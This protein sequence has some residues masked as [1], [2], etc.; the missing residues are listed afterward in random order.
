MASETADSVDG[1]A[2]RLRYWMSRATGKPFF[3]VGLVLAS[4]S[5]LSGLA[6]YLILTGL[7]PIIPTHQVVVTVLLFNGVLAFGMIVLIAWQVAGLWIAR[8]RQAPGAR[9]HA[10]IVGM[11]SIIAVLP[12]ILL[13]VFASVSLDRGLDHWF[14]TR[15]QSIV[16]NS[17]NVARAY[18]NEHGQIIRSDVISMAADIDAAADLLRNQPQRFGRYLTAQASIRSIPVAYLIDSE[19]KLLVTAGR[20]LDAPYVPPPAGTIEEADS[21]KVV[22]IAPGKTN[23][24]AAVKKLDNLS[25]NYL[26]IVRAVNP[27]VLKHMRATQASVKEYSDLAE[28]RKGVQIAFGLMY[29]AIALTLLLAAIWTGLWFAGRLVSPIRRLIRAAQQVSEGNLNVKVATTDTESDLTQLG[30]TFNNMTSELRAQ[31]KDLVDANAM[32]DERRRFIE[33]VLSGVTAGII[34][35][36]TKGVVTLANPSADNLVGVGKKQIVG[37]PI[38]SAVPEFA[39]LFERARK[40]GGKP[41][42]EHIQLIRNA[43]ERNLAVRITSERSG[44]TEYGYV[45][46]FDDITELVS[47]QRSSAWAD[48]AQRIA[49]EIKNP[50]TPIQLSAERIRR[51]YGDSITGDREV[52][53]RCTDTIIRQVENIGRMVDEF[54]SFARMPKPKMEECD[55]LEIAREAV[56]L[57]QVSHSDITF[58]LD[59]PAKPVIVNC[60][61]RLM[62]QLFTN[63]VKNASEAI[64]PES[65]VHGIILTRVRARAGRVTL[66]IIDNGRGLPK[67]NRHLLVEPYMTTR[68]QGTG[69]GLAIVKRIAEQHNGRLQL[70]D[71][72]KR[73]GKGGG[74]C[75]RIDF[76]ELSSARKPEFR[77]VKPASRKTSAKA[78]PKTK[79]KLKRSKKPRSRRAVDQGATHGV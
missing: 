17:L 3:L 63:L 72:P 36:D 61:R 37:K 50:L 68:E 16:R 57:F 54:S 42:S 40:Q 31:R 79:T 41:V 71:A 35:L 66:E 75:I 29:V 19:A 11:F 34:G 58:E 55:L 13:A 38:E 78:K 15:T 62:T 25:N 6:T 8:R 26:Y 39:H 69:L 44:K 9:L 21:G 73:N 18:L 53:D 32:L 77:T 46:T 45:V 59:M 10:R 12:A 22:V 28:R 30:T 67:E 1:R 60:D 43:E 20:L 48:V 23:K 27:R 51:K 4:L 56:F 76:P 33:T 14:S 70:L 49:H 5:I 7:T 47:A 65:G 2:A 64:D 24:V 74:A 52:F